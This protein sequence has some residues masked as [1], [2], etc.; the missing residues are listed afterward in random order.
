MLST[1]KLHLPLQVYLFHYFPRGVDNTDMFFSS[2]YSANY[3][4]QVIYIMKQMFKISCTFCWY[5][6]FLAQR[7]PLHV[8]QTAAQTLEHCHQS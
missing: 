2:L 5:E 3:S 4:C 8:T 6:S 1:P 7:C